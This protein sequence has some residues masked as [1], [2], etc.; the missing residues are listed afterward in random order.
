MTSQTFFVSKPSAQ[1]VQPNPHPCVK[2]VLSADAHMILKLN[3]HKK[4]EQFREDL[5]DAWQS[6][7]KVMK[8]LASKHHKSLWHI[9]NDLYLGHMKFHSRKS[10]INTWNAFS[11]K[12]QC[13]LN[14][15]NGNATGSTRTL[16]DLVQQNCLEYCELSAEDKDCLIE[17]FSQFKESKAMG[18]HATTKSKINDITHMLK[19]IENELHNLKS[20]TGVESMLYV[21]HGTTDLPLQGIAFTTEGVADFLS[22]V[23]DIDTQ[24]LE[25]LRTINN[26]FRMS[27]QLFAISSTVNSMSSSTLLLVGKVITHSHTGEVT[28]DPKAKMQWLEVLLQKWEMGST[29]WKKLSDNEFRE[30][31][32]A[33]NEQ[34]ENKGKKCTPYSLNAPSNKKYKSAAIINDDNEENAGLGENAQSSSSGQ[35]AHT[36]MRPINNPTP[37]GRMTMV[38]NASSA[39]Q[40]NT[41]G[42]DANS[43]VSSTVTEQKATEQQATEQQATEQQATEQQATEWQALLDQLVEDMLTFNA[44]MATLY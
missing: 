17:E 14:G 19:A 32:Q 39:M 11:W 42:F 6:L 37:A 30:L 31:Q 13:T 9:Q 44:S 43:I 38:T 8:T 16:L 41:S 10:K 22:S 33:R 3:Q 36:Q 25:R 29:H 27:M 7:D 24:D 40:T 2:V 15:L 5:D 4:V 20:C 34:L 26:A 35:P 18:I 1:L 12:K 21:T 28:G 23:M